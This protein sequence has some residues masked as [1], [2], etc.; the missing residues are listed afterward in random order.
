DVYTVLILLEKGIDVTPDGKVVPAAL[1]GVASVCR[2]LDSLLVQPLVTTN[3]AQAG[4]K[5][6][7][8]AMARGLSALT[9]IVD[10]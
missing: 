5:T 1:A 8:Q 6:A 10:T 9:R 7:R 2:P 3:V 4:G